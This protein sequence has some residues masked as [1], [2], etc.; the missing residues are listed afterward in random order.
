MKL[1]LVLSFSTILLFVSCKQ[2]DESIKTPCDHWTQANEYAFENGPNDYLSIKDFSIEGDCMTINFGASGCDGKLWEYWLYD[3]ES[4]EK[5]FPPQRK[6]RLAFTN[7]EICFSY[8]IEEASF[9]LS[10]LQIEGENSIKFILTNSEETIL[11][12]Y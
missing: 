3:S 10:P 11:Y 8:H 6:L 5:T 4:I 2:D 7:P 12:N 1:P 9:D